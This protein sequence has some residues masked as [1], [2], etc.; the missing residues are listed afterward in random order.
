MGASGPGVVADTGSHSPVDFVSFPNLTCS[1]Q[2]L[3]MNFCSPI[4]GGHWTLGN[5]LGES[6]RRRR[7]KARPGSVESRSLLISGDSNIS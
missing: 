6:C 3:N 5:P 4:F 7:S 1:G 2:D